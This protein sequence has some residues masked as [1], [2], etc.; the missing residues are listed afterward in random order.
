[1]LTRHKLKEFLRLAKSIN[2][3]D[4]LLY[5]TLSEDRYD[6]LINKYCTGDIILDVVYQSYLG[7][8][9]AEVYDYF[10]SPGAASGENPVAWDRGFIPDRINEVIYSL[11]SRPVRDSMRLLDLHFRSLEDILLKHQGVKLS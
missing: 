10:D 3:V 4:D 8:D 11:G 5:R 6:E 2:A 9:Y 7:K 1:M